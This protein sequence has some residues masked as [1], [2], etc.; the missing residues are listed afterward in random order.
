MDWR[1][2]AQQMASMARDLLAQETLGATLERITDSAVQL[3]EGCDAAGILILDGE[4][5]HS[6]AP[7]D[8]LVVESDRLQG[9]LREGPCFDA[10]RPEYGE[11]V[12]RI[13][14]FT[15]E[16]LRW[17][18]FVPHAREL[19][20]GSMMGFL[21]YT[22]EEE[23]GALNL[24]SRSPGAFTE[25]SETAGWLL[26]SHAAVAFASARSDAQLREAIN[27]RHMIGEAM[28]ILMG[29]HNITEEQAFDILR[30][31]SQK[32]NTKLRDIA[33]RVCETGSPSR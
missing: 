9:Q 4:K 13:P 33:R 6:L 18:A 20:L 23:L 8:E 28:G 2:F 16:A 30:T 21:L 31:H 26:A 10:A 5:V 22:R 17:P 3:V 19:G 24:Y 1:V 15:E 11:R 32:T 27:T 25:A 29:R 7:T 14:D 12:F